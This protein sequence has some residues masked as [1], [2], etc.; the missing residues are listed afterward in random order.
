VTETIQIESC[1]SLDGE[2]LL[3]AFAA[4]GLDGE[5]LQDAAPFTYRLRSNGEGV[6]RHVE[7]ALEDWAASRGL[8]L[9]P[10][11]LADGGFVLRPPAG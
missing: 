11:R 2:E 8:P 4:R 7:L 3:A 1:R 10:T 6:A 5:L 9:I